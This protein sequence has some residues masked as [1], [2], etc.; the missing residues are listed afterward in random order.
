ML[1][2]AKKIKNQNSNSQQ[3]PWYGPHPT[4]EGWNLREV[5]GLAQGHTASWWWPGLQPR[6][7]SPQV[8][9][10]SGSRAAGPRDTQEAPPWLC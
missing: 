7:K 1:G 8:E 3:H 9:S 6:P 4:D 5:M 2:E 10:A